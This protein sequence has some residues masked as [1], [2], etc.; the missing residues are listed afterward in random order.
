MTA[1]GGGGNT[2]INNSHKK[3]TSKKLSQANKGKKHKM[4]NEWK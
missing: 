4:S 2:W 1:G 3:E